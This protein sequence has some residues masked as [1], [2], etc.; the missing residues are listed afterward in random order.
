MGDLRR[1]MPTRRKG[2][3]I[4]NGLLHHLGFCVAVQFVVLRSASLEPRV[5]A[6]VT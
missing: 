5:A 1:Q 4:A 6:H 3:D 2:R